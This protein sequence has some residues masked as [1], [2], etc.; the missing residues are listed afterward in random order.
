MERLYLEILG[1]MVRCLSRRVENHEMQV[2]V[3]EVI[4]KASRAVSVRVSRAMFQG[5]LFSQYVWIKLSP[6]SD[7]SED[8]CVP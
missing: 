1:L 2:E 8:L 4:R 6:M 5:I 3:F 7:K